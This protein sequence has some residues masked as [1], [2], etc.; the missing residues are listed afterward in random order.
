MSM[1]S[2]AIIGIGCFFAFLVFAVREYERLQSHTD[3]KQ[4]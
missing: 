2:I 4:E 1:A 3:D